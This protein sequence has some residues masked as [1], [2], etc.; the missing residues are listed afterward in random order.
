MYVLATSFENEKYHVVDNIW[1]PEEFYT[2]QHVKR[3]RRHS[4]RLDIIDMVEKE[5]YDIC[6]FKTVWLSI[7]QRKVRRLLFRNL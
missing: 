1:N 5:N 3:M 7:F 4:L 6:I 2:N